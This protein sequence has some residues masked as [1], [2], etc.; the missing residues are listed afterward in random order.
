MKCSTQKIISEKQISFP[1]QEKKVPLPC[2]QYG[3]SRV[4]IILGGESPSNEDGSSKVGSPEYEK[5]KKNH[6]EVL[7]LGGLCVIGTERHE[8]RRIDNQLR[9][10]SGRQG[11]PGS[12]RFFVALDDDIMRLFGGETISNLMT[13]FNM[14]E[15]VPLQHGLVTKSY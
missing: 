12:T 15:D 13:R 2:Y 1:K 4:D 3:R 7:S 9:G 14:P 11:D 6:D 10:R 8:S 5:W